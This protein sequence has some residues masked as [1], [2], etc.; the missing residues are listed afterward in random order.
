MDNES[1]QL[2]IIDWI[3]FLIDII[4]EVRDSYAVEYAD[5]DAHEELREEEEDDG[6]Y[7]GSSATAVLQAAGVLG[8]GVAQFHLL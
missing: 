4:V 2:T 6:R 8:L 5:G 1:H 3:S 7:D